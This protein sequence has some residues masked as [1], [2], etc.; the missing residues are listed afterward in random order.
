MISFWG[1]VLVWWTILI[2]LISI[3]VKSPEERL[4]I[5]RQQLKEQK[6]KIAKL[7]GEETSI[8]RKLQELDKEISLNTEI[9]NTLKRKRE[10]INEEKKN[11]ELLINEL[12][13]RLKE[14]REI[15]SRRIREIYIHGP[16]H[17]VEVVLLSYSFGDAL[18]RIKFLVLIADQDRRVLK[19]IERLEERLKTQKE[20]MERK[21]ETLDEILYEVKEQEIALEK[22]KKEKNEYLTKVEGERKKAI[23]MSKE[24][25]KAMED[26]EKLIISLSTKEKTSGSVYFHKKLLGLPVEG[27]IIGYFGRKKEEKYGTE[28]I[29]KGIDIEAPLG[30]DVKA[31]APGKVVYNDHFLGYGKMILIDHGENFITLYS[32]LSSTNVEVGEEVEKGNV[33]GKVGETG[34]VKKPMLHFEVRKGGKAVN[35]LDYIKL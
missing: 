5:L 22:T 16:L 28:T 20:I 18:K 8:L 32:H 35:P 11:I 34:S 15:L 19:E 23:A 27:T 21:V 9:I 30:A 6:E 14:K 7:K 13:S 3:E 29:N 26:L 24:M 12:H 1:K 2:A 31:V 4:K 33:I 17:P 10:I 25:E